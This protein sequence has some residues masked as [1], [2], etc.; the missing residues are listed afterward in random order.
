MRVGLGLQKK[1][2][3]E[4]LTSSRKEE[5]ISKLSPGENK[6][7]TQSDAEKVSQVVKALCM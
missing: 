5:E 1:S 6:Q 3:R 4:H 7:R 2:E